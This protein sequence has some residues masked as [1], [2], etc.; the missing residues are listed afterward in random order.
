M[1]LDKFPQNLSSESPLL[2]R[3]P[4]IGGPSTPDLELHLS[5]L[6]PN[7]ESLHFAPK[8]RQIIYR[9]QFGGLQD[10]DELFSWKRIARLHPP[11]PTLDQDDFQTKQFFGVASKYKF[12]PS[13]E[14]GA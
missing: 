5:F 14:S 8:T 11:R 10:S 7:Y 1:V 6:L 2:K 3:F 9:F 13:G 12:S 4:P